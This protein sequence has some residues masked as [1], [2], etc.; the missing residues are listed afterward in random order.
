[1]TVT[2]GRAGRAF[3]ESK[4][5]P[6][7]LFSIGS[8]TEPVSSTILRLL[9]QGGKLEGAVDAASDARTALASAL[10]GIEPGRPRS[11]CGR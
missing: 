6:G 4:G 5:L 10:K 1:M 9:G 2:A 7:F 8:R 3:M 11:P